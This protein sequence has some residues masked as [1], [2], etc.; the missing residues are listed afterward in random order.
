[1]F[2]SD[3]GG[4]N[5]GSRSTVSFNVSTSGICEQRDVSTAVAVPLGHSTWP[6]MILSLAGRLHGVS[7]EIEADDGV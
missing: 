6:M 1:L 4:N 5:S 3:N 7:S 2:G